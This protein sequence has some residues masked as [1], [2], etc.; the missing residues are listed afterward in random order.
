MS[1]GNGGSD[2]NAV[3]SEESGETNTIVSYTKIQI[4]WFL[5]AFVPAVAFK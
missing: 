3:N 5:L 1:E 4:L 2:S